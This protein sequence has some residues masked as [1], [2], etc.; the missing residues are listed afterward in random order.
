MS[1]AVVLR[2]PVPTCEHAVEVEQPVEFLPVLAPEVGNAVMRK[3]E[4]MRDEHAATHEPA[5][6]WAACAYYVAH[7]DREVARSHVTRLRVGPAVWTH[8]GG[9]QV[10]VMIVH[11]GDHGIVAE[12]GGKATMMTDPTSLAQVTMTQVRTG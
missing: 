8:P 9:T 2:C 7:L 11:V 12:I 3:A 5:E 4:R 6:W 1:P 10:D